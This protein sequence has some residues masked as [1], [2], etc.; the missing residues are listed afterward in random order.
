MVGRKFKINRYCVHLLKKDRDDS[1][2]RKIVFI[3]QVFVVNRLKHF[4]TKISETMLSELTISNK[5]KLFVFAHRLTNNKNIQ[6]CRIIRKDLS[7]EAYF[8]W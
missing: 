3:K 5:K 2:G 4:E 8:F 1:G 7:S 6:S